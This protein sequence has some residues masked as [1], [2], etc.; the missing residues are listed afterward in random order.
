M[1]ENLGVIK[2]TWNKENPEEV[3]LAEEKFIEYTRQGWIAFSTT[4]D[5][6]RMQIFTFNPELKEVLLVLLVE[7]G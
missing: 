7:G 5:G 2:I 4:A 3:R 1:R 6:R